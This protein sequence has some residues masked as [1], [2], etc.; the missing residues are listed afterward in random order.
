MP[1]SFDV[2][3]TALMQYQVGVVSVAAG[4]GFEIYENLEYTGTASSVA[5]VSVIAGGFNELNVAPYFGY[6]LSN[7]V[8]VLSD[9]LT[10]QS[11]D[12]LIGDTKW[13]I[14]PSPNALL[15]VVL[16]SSENPVDVTDYATG[17]SPSSG[18]TSTLDIPDA[19]FYVYDNVIPAAVTDGQATLSVPL[20]I[21]HRGTYDLFAQ[22]YYSSNPAWSGGTLSLSAG[23]VEDTLNTSG[24]FEGQTNTF[25][26]RE[27]SAVLG[28]GMSLD[29]S[30][31]AGWNA[32]S[33][34]FV[35]PEGEF[36][37]AYDDFNS[38]VESEHIQVIQLT[39]G[40]NLAPTPVSG[41]EEYQTSTTNSGYSPFGQ[42]SYLSTLLP[43]SANLTIPVA[44]TTGAALVLDFLHTSG[45]LLRV[46]FAGSSYEFG[47]SSQSF[48]TPSNSAVVSLALPLGNLEPSI[49]NLS[50][51]SGFVFLSSYAVVSTAALPVSP[52]PVSPVVN[53]TSVF[54]PDQQVSSYNSSVDS[55]GKTLDI[56]LGFSFNT[57]SPTYVPLIGLSYSL[58]FDYNSSISA[59][60]SIQ[61]GFYLELNSV[62]VGNTNAS[63]VYISA[64]AYG[65]L[66]RKYSP[67]L[68]LDVYREPG[69][70]NVTMGSVTLQIS[71]SFYNDS[72][73]FDFTPPNL[74]TTQDAINYDL[75]G[76]SLG[77]CE[78][79]VWIRLPFYGLMTAD[80][81]N[82]GRLSIEDGVGQLL[83]VPFT[84]S[85]SVETTYVTPVLVTAVVGVAVEVCC[86]AVSWISGRRSRISQ[87]PRQGQP[88]VRRCPSEN[89]LGRSR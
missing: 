50:L 59:S 89:G 42:V 60:L 52:A 67:N 15:G 87:A 69:S 41:T 70:S 77:N 46:S 61:S 19:N 66:D 23:G 65:S 26:W 33:D 80:P 20:S 29:V 2:N 78:G 51:V 28:P 16:H 71:M 82:V 81:G 75:V 45:G 43:F 57:S 31:V 35:L 32:V 36:Q 64:G 30:S 8:P 17:S 11:Y 34:I 38:S 10:E 12:N 56:A 88:R 4:P 25:V 18:W 21:S 3:A 63:P 9:D 76:Y 54:S 39:A 74:V 5:G 86:V 14:T 49:L 27:F 68:Y 13:I 6:N 55:N 62:L 48:A 72:S 85:V 53:L 83:S 73:A 84:E 1:F 44:N 22:V 79:L 47:I 37:R 7:E 58:P 40:A 24:S